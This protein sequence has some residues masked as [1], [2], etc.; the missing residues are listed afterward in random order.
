MTRAHRMKL[1][2]PARIRAL[3]PALIAVLI[4]VLIAAACGPP[5]PLVPV[6]PSSPDDAQRRAIEIGDRV[7]ADQFE[8][9]PEYPTS[10]LPPGAT[11]DGLPDDSIAAVAAR[12]AKLA[13]WRTELLSIKRSALAGNTQA[14]LS[15]QVAREVLESTVRTHVCREELWTVSPAGNGWPARFTT[16][17]ELQPVGT[18]ALRTQA[19]ARFRKMGAYVDAQ[20]ANLREGMR[21]GYLAHDGSVRAVIGQLD[22]LLAT[23]ADK[24]PFLSPADRDG[25]PDFRARLVEVLATS[26]LPAIERYRDFLASEYLPYARS[27]PGVSRNPQGADC[28]RAVLRSYTT[29]DLD[30]AEAHQTGWDALAAV[31][32]DMKALADRSF[33]GT[34]IKALLA[35][36]RNDAQYRYRDRDE[37]LALA[38][39]AV[40]RAKAALPRAFGLLPPGDVT[41]EPV[42]D[43]L[44]KTSGASYSPAA[45]DG[46]RPATFRIRLY[47]PDQQSRV[48][49]E[50]TAFHEALPGHHLQIDIA[51]RRPGV[52]AIARELINIGYSEGWALYAEGVADEL[53]LYSSDADRMGMLSN[54]AWRAVRVIVDTGIHALGW[55]RQ[56]ALDTLLAHTALSEE[57]AQSQVDRYIAYPG[58]A[59]AYMI[60]YLEIVRLRAEAQQALGTRFDLRAFHDRVLEDGAMPLPALR[61]KIE[62]WIGATV[63]ERRS[64]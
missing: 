59:C 49:D 53:G 24:S 2:V 62:A 19:L 8:V 51:L 47:R 48:I 14:R 33:G 20:I 12:A 36:L 23:P 16:L 26:L 28:Y 46:S 3:T 55:D 58:Q 13:S 4:A 60:G 11:F 7:R 29:L 56:K 9:F 21:E 42:P 32:A 45:L 38:N 64:R 6:V 40:A 37:M 27:L 41:V 1:V 50:G 25:T 52:P 54:R 10:L 30:P 31:E 61:A 43:F 35:A 39:A 17:V 44:A 34:D 22:R 5:P 15:Y 18:D 57:Q 63:A